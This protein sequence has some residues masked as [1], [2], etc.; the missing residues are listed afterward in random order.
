MVCLHATFIFQR[1]NAL[2]PTKAWILRVIQRK[3]CNWCWS[4]RDGPNGLRKF[5]SFQGFVSVHNTEKITSKLC[6]RG[7]K[8]K[9]IGQKVKKPCWW[10]IPWEIFLPSM[11]VKTWQSMGF[12]TDSGLSLMQLSGM[13]KYSIASKLDLFDFKNVKATANEITAKPLAIRLTR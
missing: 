3:R 7:S 9:I 6:L 4:S 13:V 11:A 10:G 2:L 1:D 8:R 5:K 12:N